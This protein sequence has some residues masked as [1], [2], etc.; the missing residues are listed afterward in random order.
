MVKTAFEDYDLLPIVT[1]P[2]AAASTSKIAQALRMF[3]DHESCR[4]SLRWIFAFIDA[5]IF[6][7]S[8][9]PKNS[10]KLII[11]YEFQSLGQFVEREGFSKYIPVLNSLHQN[12][13]VVILIAVSRIMLLSLRKLW[14]MCQELMICQ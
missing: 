11:D 10:V 14:K 13:V 7:L 9:K 3:T 4:A 1:N 6:I 12:V 2:S 8:L 5:T